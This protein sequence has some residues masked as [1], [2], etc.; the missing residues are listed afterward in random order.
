MALGFTECLS[1]KVE[2]ATFWTGWGAIASA[3]VGLVTVLIAALAW[4]T[5]RRA[6][7]IAR[8]ATEIASDQHRE[9]VRQREESARIL[10]R[11]LQTEV[12]T[13]PERVAVVLRAWTAAIEWGKPNRIKNHLAFETALTQARLPFLPTAASVESRLHNFPDVLGADLATLIGTLKTFNDLADR[14]A[15][16]VTIVK[17]PP[18]LGGGFRVLYAGNNSEFEVLKVS[19]RRHLGMS[20]NMA[21]RMQHFNGEEIVDYSAQAL[22]LD[23]GES[24]Y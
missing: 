1:M 6:T 3:F 9:T 17:D 19:L 2:C 15:A 21:L 8:L 16:K 10:G 23:E 5:S 11:L 18:D 22:L 20:I 14:F 24:D 4:W 12:A 13:L 7:Q